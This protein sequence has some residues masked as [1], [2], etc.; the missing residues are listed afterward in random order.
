M[1]LFSS[2]YTHDSIFL[3]SATKLQAD[4]GEGG[5]ILMVALKLEADVSPTIELEGI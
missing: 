2:D 4:Q 3:W 5:F 1:V